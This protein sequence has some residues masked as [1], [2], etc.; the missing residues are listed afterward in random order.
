M[1]GNTT[2]ARHQRGL[3]ITGSP[4]AWGVFYLDPDDRQ[5]L[6]RASGNESLAHM[7]EAIRQGRD[8][9]HAFIWEPGERYLPFITGIPEL[10][11]FRIDPNQP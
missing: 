7:R 11:V 3:L 5:V 6:F 4:H 2:A 1:C 8:P 10:V 9:R